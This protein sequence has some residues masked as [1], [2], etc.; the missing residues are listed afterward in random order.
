MKTLLYSFFS[1]IIRCVLVYGG[2]LSGHE[3]VMRGQVTCATCR[4]R[5]CAPNRVGPLQLTMNLFHYWTHYCT[6][7]CLK[8]GLIFVSVT[9]IVFLI[10]C[11]TLM[12]KN[13]VTDWSFRVICSCMQK[14]IINN[15]T[16]IALRCAVKSKYWL[17][18]IP[19][20][21]HEYFIKEN[22]LSVIL[23]ITIQ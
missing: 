5:G 13:R 12:L 20:S 3:R 23:G 4:R 7:Y 15:I 21:L 22:A 14:D 8:N 1:F 18:T 6:T 9:Q 10:V 19:V 11:R 16:S 2:Q 17:S